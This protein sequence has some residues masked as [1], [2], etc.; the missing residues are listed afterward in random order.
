MKSWIKRTLI[1]L[2][3][4]GIVFGGA[5]ACSHRY[6]HDGWQVSEEDAAKFRGKMIERAAKE[7]ALDEAQKQRLGAL[8]DAVQA[9]RKALVGETTNP[10]AELQALVAGP[11][12]DR[13]RAQSLVDAKTAAVQGKS[14][15]VIAAA[16]A[17]YDGLNAEQQQKLRDF[18]TRRHHGWRG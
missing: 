3:G 8:A 6:H 18:M 2:F 13:A 10:R 7:L 15:E 16:A 9:Q 14:P 5:A 11:T 12:F 4:A 17:F 1:G